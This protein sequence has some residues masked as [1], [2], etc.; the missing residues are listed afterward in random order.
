M[1][2]KV[3]VNFSGPWYRLMAFFCHLFILLKLMII[4]KSEKAIFLLV[5]GVFVTGYLLGMIVDDATVIMYPTD[6]IAEKQVFLPAV[7]NYGKG[8]AVPVE[9]E[10]KHGEGKVLTDIDKLLFWVDTQHSIQIARDVA[11]NITGIDTSEYDLIYTIGINQSGIVG[12]PSAGGALTIA[13]IAALTNQTVKPGIMMTGTIDENGNV[14]AVGGILDKAKAAKE[15]GAIILL[16]PKEQ[17]TDTNM[18]PVQ[19]CEDILGLTYC[20]TKYEKQIINIGETA[21]I[22]VI[23]IENIRDAVKYFFE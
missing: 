20:T 15:I 2:K 22:T 23:E 13:T 17:S 5:C 11:S 1:E 18:I 19:T 14:G 12:G 16:V 4:M 7:D 9:V 3:Q 10:I 6:S 21:G 8:V